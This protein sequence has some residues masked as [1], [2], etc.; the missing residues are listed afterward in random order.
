[1][2]AVSWELAAGWR[3]SEAHITVIGLPFDD[4]PRLPF[5][6]LNLGSLL[7]DWP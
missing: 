7:R 5:N 6:K 1:M 2:L 3:L 4:H